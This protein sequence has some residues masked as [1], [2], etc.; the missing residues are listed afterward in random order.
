MTK[1]EFLSVLSLYR[2]RFKSKYEKPGWNKWALFGAF[3]SLIWIFISLNEKKNVNY[4]AVLPLLIFMIISIPYLTVLFGSLISKDDDKK[5][6][7]SIN[8]IVSDN[9]LSLTYGFL[10]YSAILLYALFY[11][12]PLKTDLLFLEVL[13][14][15][16]LFSIVFAVVISLIKNFPPI[17]KKR[18][19]T[20]LV[21]NLLVMIL[22]V[23]SLYPLCKVI[24]WDD[25][26]IWKLSL[27]LFGLY[28]V[29]KKLID[30][31]ERNSMIDAI[32]DL[33]DD[34]FFENV[35]SIEEAQNRLKIIVF[36]LEFKDLF[37]PQVKE[38]IAIH[39]KLRNSIEK[40]KN[41]VDKYIEVENELKIPL[42]ESVAQN[43]L[44]L[45]SISEELKDVWKRIKSKLLYFHHL[46]KGS[47][48]YQDILDVFENLQDDSLSKVNELRIYIEGT[49]G[50]LD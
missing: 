1:A 7:L 14:V 43:L 33:M 27:V 50:L 40:T 21:I 32:D 9:I 46:E 41:R 48:D 29:I 44:D 2:E 6:Y 10:T 26:E 42:K 23:F 25:Y 31:T 3:A 19:K 17:P 8:K 39:D 45:A 49:P 18:S 5:K 30:D 37:A 20:S 16:L 15:W 24:T 35:S 36:G 13:V 11:P 28:F 47:K 4:N 22:Y 34:V 38:F 12:K